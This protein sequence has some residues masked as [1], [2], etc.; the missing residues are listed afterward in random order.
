LLRPLRPPAPPTHPTHRPPRRL[1]ALEA[2]AVDAVVEIFTVTPERAA[3]VRFVRPFYAVEGGLLWELPEAPLAP[4]PVVWTDLADK[5]I[6]YQAGNY[7]GEALLAEGA[8]PVAVER[9]DEY[10]DAIREGRCAAA[11]ADDYSAAGAGLA[12]APLP[13]LAAAPYSVAVSRDAAADDLAL[14]VSGAMVNL[15]TGPDAPLVAEQ[16]S[17]FAAIGVAPS[18]AVAQL[19]RA[20]TTM[21][22]CAPGEGAEAAPAPPA[23]A[24]P[25]R[26]VSG[27]LAAALAMAA[28]ALL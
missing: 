16:R 11:V 28:A 6:C 23:S 7:L 22:A 26:R 17:A 19:S 21:D 15:L 3:R 27:A 20:L 2:G 25:R 5:K 8:E 4:P 1:T 9:I 14:R 12:A 13:P 18:P 10:A 24:S